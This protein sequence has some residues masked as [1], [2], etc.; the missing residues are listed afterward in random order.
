MKNNGFK[1]IVFGLLFVVLNFT[2]RLEDAFILNLIPNFLGYGLIYQGLLR[3]ETH[4]ENV[5]LNTIKRLTIVLFIFTL[6][7]FFI[8]LFGISIFLNASHL[9]L[10]LLL[11]LSNLVLHLIFLFHLTKTIISINK[12]ESDLNKK[13]Y[14][15]FQVIVLVDVVSM[16]FIAFPVI[17]FFV[18]IG[19]LIANIM[20]ILTIKNIGDLVD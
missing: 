8:D 5:H 1:H 6:V 4:F 2:I 3:F 16:F 19:G 15:L 7:L 20:Y 18:I 11:S 13:L 10:G 9:W 12:M 17:G 14:T